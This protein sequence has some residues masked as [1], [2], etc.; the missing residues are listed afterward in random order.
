MTQLRPRADSI[1]HEEK[2]H[3]LKDKD[4]AKT[5]VNKQSYDLMIEMLN[6]DTIHDMVSLFGY[7]IESRIVTTKDS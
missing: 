4:V 7:E 2:Y 6:A 3:Y 1:E 5:Q